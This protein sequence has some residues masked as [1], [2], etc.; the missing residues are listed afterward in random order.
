MRSHINIDPLNDGNR[1][2][3]ILNLFWA[4]AFTV[5]KMEWNSAIWC[6]KKKPLLTRLDFIINIIIIIHILNMCFV[7]LNN[8]NMIRVKPICLPI[9]IGFL[10]IHNT[11]SLVYSK[12]KTSDW[13]YNIV[14]QRFEAKYSSHIDYTINFYRYIYESISKDSETVYFIYS[15]SEH[16]RKIILEFF[17]QGN[18]FIGL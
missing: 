6:Q 5:E 7:H 12:L 17:F 1:S 10:L 13:Q 16:L 11:S 9:N 4:C 8:R 2:Q 3:K 14:Y 15:I 18:V